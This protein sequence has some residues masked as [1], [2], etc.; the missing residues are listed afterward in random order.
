MAIGTGVNYA[1]RKSVPL[2]HRWIVT[3]CA[4]IVGAAATT[5]FFLV[6]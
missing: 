4:T 5:V 6:P 2:E 1:G 3:I